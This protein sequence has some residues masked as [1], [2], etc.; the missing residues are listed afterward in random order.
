VQGLIAFLLQGKAYPLLAFLFG[1][2]L[3]LAGRGAGNHASARSAKRLRKLLLLGVLHGTLLYYGDI[4]TMYALCGMLVLSKVHEPFKRMRP[5]L[6]KSVIWAVTVTLVSALLAGWSGGPAAGEAQT[7][8]LRGTTSVSDF[9]ALNASAYAVMQ[10]AYLLMFLPVLR[11]FMLAGITAARLRLLTHPRWRRLRGATVRRLLWPALAANAVYAL[12]LVSSADE[13]SALH[14]CL[15][16]LS[17]LVGAPLS[18]AFCACAAL[19][20]QRGA[21]AWCA[22]LA[23]LGQRTLSLYIGTSVLCM[24]LFSG[25]GASWRVG[26]AGMLAFA[27]LVWGAAWALSALARRQ[28]W[29]GPL[30]AW[31]AQ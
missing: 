26:N 30:E 12:L 31:V 22:W 8:T 18:M 20:W 15:L 5:R 9:V 17:P 1:M 27:L 28:A 14:W 16:A 21:R 11:C 29:R 13:P 19:A 4:L 6:R 2:S 23:P 24:W 10:A 3:A 7:P 25:A